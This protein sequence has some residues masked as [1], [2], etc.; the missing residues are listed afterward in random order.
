MPDEPLKQDDLSAPLP[1]GPNSDPTG[2]GPPPPGAET[3]VTPDGHGVTR[4][5][6]PPQGDGEPSSGEDKP[7]GA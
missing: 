4:S 5:P 7:P 2:I 6:L 1:V 3:E